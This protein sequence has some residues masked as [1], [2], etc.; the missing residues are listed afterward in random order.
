M[1]IF[2]ILKDKTVGS[3]DVSKAGRILDRT[4]DSFYTGT[5]KLDKPIIQETGY[6]LDRSEIRFYDSKGMDKIPLFAAEPSIAD[7]KQEDI[8]DCYFLGALNAVVE[9]DPQIIKNNMVDEG[10]TVVVRFFDPSDG[11]PV[12]VRVKKTVPA[13]RYIGRNRQGQPVFSEERIYGSKGALWVNMMEKAYAAVRERMSPRYRK[14]VKKKLKGYDC[15]NHA[16]FVDLAVEVITGKKVD[17]RILPSSN[18]VYKQFTEISKLFSHVH[19][20][21]KEAFMRG[22]NENGT[23]RRASDWN[24][25]KAKA[26][27]GIDITG[28][29]NELLELFRK[30]RLFE[31]YEKY[32]KDHLTK[33]FQSKRKI[34]LFTTGA[35][36]FYT[37]NDLNLFLDS[38]D[39][40]HMPDLNLGHG[41]DEQKVKRHYIEYFRKSI[42]DSG[43]L[44]IGVNTSGKYSET[45]KK[46]FR[47]IEKHTS[48][49]DGKKEIVVAISAAHN[50]SVKGNAAIRG[51]SG[52]HVV[53][54]IA[55]PHAYSIMGTDIRE[56]T[57]GG[58]K[59]KQRFVIIHNPWNTDVI[60][61]YDKDTLRPYMGKEGT[62]AKG[63]FLMELTDF[64]ESFCY[65]GVEKTKD[66]GKEDVEKQPVDEITKD[67]R[68][69]VDLSDEERESGSEKKSKAWTAEMTEMVEKVKKSPEYEKCTPMAKTIID[70]IGM[71]MTPGLSLQKRVELENNVMPVLRSIRKETNTIHSSKDQEEKKRKSDMLTGVYGEPGILLMF[72]S[73]MFAVAEGD[74]QLN[75]NE[76]IVDGTNDDLFVEETDFKEPKTADDGRKIYHEKV[77]F[78]PGVSDRTHM[79]LFSK[80]PSSEDILQGN[81]GDCYAIAALNAIVECD[82]RYIREA[83]K[84][85]GDTVVV[86]FF[87]YKT[88]DPVYVRVKKTIALTEYTLRDADGKESKAYIK[89]GARGALWVNI[90]EKAFAVARPLLN[91]PKYKADIKPKGFSGIDSG[92]SPVF[93][94]IFTGKELKIEALSAA[95]NKNKDYDDIDTLTDLV[96]SKEKKRFMD[97]RNEDGSKRTAKDWNIY[98]AKQ[99]FGLD[100]PPGNTKLYDMFR[101]NTIL[102]AYREFMKK[103]LDAYF[104]SPENTMGEAGFYTSNDLNLFLNTI[105]I[106]KMPVFNLGSGIDED[107]LK[108]HYIEY[109]RKT[110]IAEGLLKNSFL[111]EGTYSDKEEEI[112]L[113]LKNVCGGGADNKKKLA[114][115]SMRNPTL[116][117]KKGD[118][119]GT[120]GEKMI[121]GIAMKHAYSI[122]GVTTKKLKI[123]GKTVERKFV[124]VVNPWRSNKIRMYDKDTLAAYQNTAD[125]KE[126][127]SKYDAKGTFL[128]EL[129]DFCEST[130]TIS[131]EGA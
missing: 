33:N 129:R 21:G 114:M 45:E 95:Y 93:V 124:E 110:V 125:K 38:I 42:A 12:Y 77:M 69:A 22:K 88:M 65:Y 37:M 67:Y 54:G 78:D 83:M 128:M 73:L 27:F 89:K 70:K 3:L 2:D 40:S 99:M 60:R 105:D 52:E 66:T 81:I 90:F 44:K 61:L 10:S 14:T 102:S 120:N 5:K 91:D 100:I 9:K 96:H 103:H 94:K 72:A 84:D 64:C 111:M 119:Q 1:R 85:E 28:E 18:T 121:F 39:I 108:K 31:A 23:E 50:L 35:P 34:D 92:Q 117:L 71:L 16:G 82:P 48:D 63:T 116:S 30:N 131:Y 79:A 113:K 127:G 59:V 53:A 43:L 46:I 24:K 41:I 86:R 13:R 101:K 56:V 26:I 62:Q 4:D 122:T 55:D 80:D 98:K 87:N 75:G 126:D 106:N 104:E 11:K 49:K 19:Y 17:I 7:I 58:K 8:G 97:K 130:Y 123:K 118:R 112:Y 74:L 68:P 36:A 107:D 47:D 109:F 25:Y 51:T 32:L 115:A 15:L 29:N 57:I 76:K 6:I 20:G